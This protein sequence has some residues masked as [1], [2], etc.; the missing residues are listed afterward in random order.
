MDLG[1]WFWKCRLKILVKKVSYAFSLWPLRHIVRLMTIENDVLSSFVWQK[2]SSA[3]LLTLITLITL[4]VCCAINYQY[5]WMTHVLIDEQIR[6]MIYIPHELCT[7]WSHTRLKWRCS[8]YK[9][10]RIWRTIWVMCSLNAFK[11][12]NDRPL[13]F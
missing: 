10:M 6:T 1:C 7:Y 4:F 2:T 8:Y 5:V 12:E 13:F 9:K 11:L 3:N